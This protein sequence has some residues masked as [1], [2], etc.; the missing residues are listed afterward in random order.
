MLPWQGVAAGRWEENNVA[1]RI[2]DDVVCR[3]VEHC[4]SESR[5]RSA[6]ARR[7]SNKQRGTSR[8]PAVRRWIRDEIGCATPGVAMS[9]AEIAACNCVL[10]MKVV[11][12]DVPFNFTTA[13]G[14]K[15]EPFNVSVNAAPPE[16]AELGFSNAICGV[17]AVGAG[18]G[19][20]TGNATGVG[21]L[22]GSGVTSG[23]ASSTS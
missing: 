16:I 6:C 1:H 9:L 21:G 11:V 22:L 10:E 4:H 19:A 12:R 8:S 23:P 7:R 20:G 17:A 14:S 13:A 3:L 15:L 5:S 2:E 18:V